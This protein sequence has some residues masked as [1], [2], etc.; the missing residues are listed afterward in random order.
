M[1]AV[2][3]REISNVKVNDIPQNEIETTR[4]NGARVKVDLGF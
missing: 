1:L 2:E 3:L 4:E